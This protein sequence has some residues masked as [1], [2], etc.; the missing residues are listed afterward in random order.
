MR[1]FLVC[2]AAFT[3]LIAAAQIY[4]AYRINGEI[5]VGGASAEQVRAVAGEPVRVLDAGD[6]GGELWVYL[7]RRAGTGK[8][9]TVSEGGKRE[10]VF[11][12]HRE[13][14]QGIPR[15]RPIGT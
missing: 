10:L 5:L 6:R 3:P 15:S 14:M 9:E 2:I 4:S 7:C 13:R 12:I 11:H 1:R 8:C